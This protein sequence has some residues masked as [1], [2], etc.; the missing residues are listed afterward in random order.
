M[1]QNALISKPFFTVLPVCT[2]W[3]EA[4]RVFRLVPEHAEPRLGPRLVPEGG[5]QGQALGLQTV[6]R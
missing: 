2:G 1:T 6:R 5:G 4:G 3:P